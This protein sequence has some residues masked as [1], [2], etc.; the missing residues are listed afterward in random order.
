MKNT[1]KNLAYR[2][3]ESENELTVLCSGKLN[4]V[5]VPALAKDISEKMNGQNRLIL[6]F[7]ELEYMSSSGLRFILK[8]YKD[9]NSVDGSLFLRNVRKDVMSVFSL[10][11]LTD[12]LTFV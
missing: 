11:G 2:F 4:A 6:D 10:T 7:T 3:E 1:E 8:L 9:M 5:T 12:Y